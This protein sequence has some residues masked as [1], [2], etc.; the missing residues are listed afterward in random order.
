MA[1]VGSGAQ[2][3]SLI[4]L[5]HPPALATVL[6]MGGRRASDSLLYAPLVV[7]IVAADPA[8]GLQAFTDPDLSDEGRQALAEALG[9]SGDYRALE[10]LCQATHALDEELRIAALRG[11]ASL[12]HPAAE[13]AVLNALEDPVWMVRSAACEAAGRIGLGSAIPRLASQLEDPM[14]WVRFWAGEA[15]WALGAPGRAQQVRTL[16]E[17]GDV[18]RRT[19]SMVLPSTASAPRPLDGDRRRGAGARR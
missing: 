16:T 3:R 1:Q 15:L 2:L 12:G 5:G 4:E 19:A 11:L 18:A 14:W 6:E 17:G 7:L 8:A 13:P 9:R 10:T